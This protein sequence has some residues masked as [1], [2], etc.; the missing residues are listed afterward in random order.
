MS[1]QV[2]LVTIL[3]LFLGRLSPLRSLLEL[4]HILSSVT[5]TTLLESGERGKW[6][7]KWFNDQFHESYVAKLGLKL[8]NPDSVV[9]HAMTALWNLLLLSLI[10]LSNLEKSVI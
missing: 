7:Q 10:N 1:C 6:P 2:G 9:R 5:D 4:V 3:T 8:A